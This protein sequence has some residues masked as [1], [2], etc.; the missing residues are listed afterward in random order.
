MVSL[1]SLIA[2]TSLISLIEELSANFL[3]YRKLSLQRP[4]IVLLSH[5]G[6]QGA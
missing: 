3:S 5:S 2:L 1:I 6:G 4:T